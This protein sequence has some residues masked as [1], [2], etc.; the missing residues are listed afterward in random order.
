MQI[1]MKTLPGTEAALGFPAI[2]A[3]EETMDLLAHAVEHTHNVINPLEN[4]CYE[5]NKNKVDMTNHHWFMPAV[6]ATH[7]VLASCI[8]S[9]L[10][11]AE[12]VWPHRPLYRRS[13]VQDIT[14]KGRTSTRAVTAQ[15]GLAISVQ[16]DADKCCVYPNALEMI[17]VLTYA[18]VSEFDTARVAGVIMHFGR[19]NCDLT[20]KD[21]SVQRQMS[22]THR[23]RNDVYDGVELA[24]RLD[25][26]RQTVITPDPT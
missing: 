3:M 22:F 6:L 8:K 9:T 18:P 10:P 5:L 16:K 23:S 12:S 26:L 2:R 17:L 7:E 24:S 4:M 11:E 19:R 14:F 21:Q 1:T 20:V 13:R 25:W 15:L